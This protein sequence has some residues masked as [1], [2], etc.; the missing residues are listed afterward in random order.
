M[1]PPL[2]TTVVTGMADLPTH[3]R[4]LSVVVEPVPSC[5]EHMATAR[6]YGELRPGTHKIDICLWNHSA[7]QVTLP[8]QTTMVEIS[9][10][11]VSLALLAQKPTGLKRGQGKTTREMKN[12]GQ[13]EL[14]TGYTSIF[15]MSDMDI[16]KTSLIMH[17][18]K[19]TDNTPFKE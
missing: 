5:S 16:G 1:I 11:D 2:M 18:I 14:I 3:L 6:S 7:M 19:L 12:E 9:S 4:S 13:K 10:A 17:S 8:Q 15:A